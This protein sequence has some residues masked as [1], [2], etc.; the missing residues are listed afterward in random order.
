MEIL[1]INEFVWTGIL[2]LGGFLMYKIFS[3]FFL[4]PI[5]ELRQWKG[6]IAE[7]LILHGPTFGHLAKEEDNKIARER[8]R[9]LRGEGDRIISQIPIYGFLSIF[10]VLPDRKILKKAMESLNG[11]SN[12]GTDELSGTHSTRYKEKLRSALQLGNY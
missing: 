8:F 3:P 5:K 1:S 7:A 6:K 11:L 2:A 9:E 10:R 12:C 4:D